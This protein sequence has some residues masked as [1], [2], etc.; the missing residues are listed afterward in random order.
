MDLRYFLFCIAV[1]LSV[2]VG[3]E[4]VDQDIVPGNDSCSYNLLTVEMTKHCSQE[5]FIYAPIKLIPKRHH[6]YLFDNC[7][8]CSVTFRT[9]VDQ[10]IVATIVL[11]GTDTEGGDRCELNRLDIYDGSNTDP[12]N[13]I[14]GKHGI[15][16]CKVPFH[17]EFKST[18]NTM[19]FT[20]QTKCDPL[21]SQHG[22]LELIL[23]TVQND[24]FNVTA[25]NGQFE[26]QNGQCID[27]NLVCN[28]EFDC[29]DHSDEQNCNIRNGTCPGKFECENGQC[30]DKNLVCNEIFDC[31]DHSDETNCSRRDN[32]TCPGMFE[33]RNGKCIDKNEVCNGEHNCGGTDTSDETGCD[34]KKNDRL[35]LYILIGIAIACLIMFIVIIILVCCRY[36]CV[37]WRVAATYRHLA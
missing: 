26:C 28:G 7:L 3:A 30:I 27:K 12:S 21:R 31:V 1:C 20:F 25:C 36:C 16:G 4:D 9:S 23:T 22:E 8:N 10:Q 14:S 17:G 6:F 2:P 32:G 34:N 19:T 35:L 24:I 15:C 37:S 5:V 18:N 13:L 29:Y 33:C 11:L